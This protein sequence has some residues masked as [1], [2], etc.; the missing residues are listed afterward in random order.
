MTAKLD[1]ALMK[2]VAA[3]AFDDIIKALTE[4]LTKEEQ[5]VGD[6][7]FNETPMTFTG[8]NYAEAY[9]TVPAVLCRK[10]NGRRNAG[11]PPNE[12][13]RRLDAY[14]D[15][16]TPRQADWAHGAKAREGDCGEDR[17]KRG[18]GRGKTGV[19]SRHNR[20]LSRQF[21]DKG[22]NQYHIVNEILPVTFISG[23]IIEEIGLNNESGYLAPGYRANATIGRALLMCM[24]NIGWRDMKY[25]SSPGGAGQP[26]AYANY[27][28]P[29]NQKESPWISYAESCGFST[30]ESIVTVCE[31]LSVIRGPARNAI[32][33]NVRS[34]VGKDALYILTAYQCFL[35]LWYASAR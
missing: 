26:V 16:P 2:S 27:I 22:F 11:G 9:E 35:T 13:S 34:K 31:T 23:P 10:R 17:N 7:I 33:G 25:Y 1:P 4:P 18:H 8:A 14:R 20:P 28:I 5:E 3:A 12:R 15:I 6:F 19:P 32:Y 24:I 21:T 30:G 29:E